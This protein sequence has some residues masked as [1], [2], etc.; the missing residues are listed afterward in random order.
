VEW[1]YKDKD[2][3]WKSSGNFSRNEIPMAVYCLFMAFAAMV[4][5]K[6]GEEGE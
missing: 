2:R 4:E 5:E 6:D 3:T 1:R